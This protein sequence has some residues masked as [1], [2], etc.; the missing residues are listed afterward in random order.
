MGM[1]HGDTENLE[2]AFRQARIDRFS[3]CCSENAAEMLTEQRDFM[4]FMNAML[5]D[6]GLQ[7]QDILL[8]ADVPLRYGYKLLAEEKKTLKRDVLLRICYAAELTLQE[9]QRA[10]KIYGM[11]PLYAR[12]PRDAILIVC[13]CQRPG[14]I[15]DVNEYLRQNGMPPLQS[16]G[17]SE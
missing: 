1:F 5:R 16:V 2:E 14:E 11:N 8:K 7:K 13:F 15:H 9:L 10:L 3:E 4:K 17:Y 6:K 12:N